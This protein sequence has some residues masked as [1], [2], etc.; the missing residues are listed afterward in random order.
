MSLVSWRP[1]FGILNLEVHPERVR[2]HCWQW[3]LDQYSAMSWKWCQCIGVA[4]ILSG[5]AL[6]LTK[7]AY[8]LFLVVALKER[9]NTPPNLTRPAKNCPKNYS[10]SGALHVLRGCTYT[11]SLY[12]TPE[13]NV[14]S[15]PWGCRC[16][17]CTPWLRLCASERFRCRFCGSL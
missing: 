9:L 8:D 3:K 10:C 2:L 12:I 1:S 11:F 13:K 16:T 7:K 5:G 14:S 15:P 17:H 6:F 4:R